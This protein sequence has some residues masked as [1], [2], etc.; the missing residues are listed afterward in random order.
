MKTFFK[1]AI[2]GGLIALGVLYVVQRQHNRI[3]TQHENQIATLQGIIASYSE[4]QFALSQKLTVLE[5]EHTRVIAD[6]DSVALLSVAR[7]DSLRR[8]KAGIKHLSASDLLSAFEYRVKPD[9]FPKVVQ[10]SDS[11]V[12]KVVITFQ[13]LDVCKAETEYLRLDLKYCNTENNILNLKVSTLT[14]QN[15][16]LNK[17]IELRKDIEQQYHELSETAFGDIKKLQREN[18]LLKGIAIIEL[19]VLVGIIL[20]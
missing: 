9:T 15:D 3:N 5:H 17:E 2:V 12:L 13:E 6:R 16:L 7:L 20:F 14:D 11:G 10:L 19:G 8:I 18:R 1:Y 4:Q